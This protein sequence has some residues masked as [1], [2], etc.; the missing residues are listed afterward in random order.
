MGLSRMAGDMTG[1][2]SGASVG[3]MSNTIREVGA[4]SKGGKTN[5]NLEY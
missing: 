4:A 5:F 2:Q 3:I 1:L